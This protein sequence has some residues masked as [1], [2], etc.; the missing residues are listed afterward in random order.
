MAREVEV[1]G[2]KVQAMIDWPIPKNVT[3]LRGF[4]SFMGYY[5]RFVKD[6]GTVAEPLT[7]LLQK[8]GFMWSDEVTKAFRQM[9]QL[10]MTLP[11]LALPKF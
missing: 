9:M 11:M 4:L 3:K 2:Q 10:M 8:N 1:D 5:K 7:A 6:Y